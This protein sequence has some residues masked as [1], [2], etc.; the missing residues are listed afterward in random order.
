MVIVGINKLIL[1]VLGT[2]GHTHGVRDLVVE[3]VKD[4]IDSRSLQFGVASIAPF[5][6]VVCLPTLDWMDMDCVGIM[7]VEE[8]DIVYTTGGGE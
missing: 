1:E 7:I 5:D 2:D 4:W 8:K 6:E 3:F